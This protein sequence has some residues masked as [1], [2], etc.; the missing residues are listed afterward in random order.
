MNYWET[1]AVAASSVTLPSQR[2]AVEVLE[3]TA[4]VTG[5]GRS[6]RNRLGRGGSAF[7]TPP[8]PFKRHHHS[9]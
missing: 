8:L 9:A 2:L 7:T 4:R 6:G 5:F 3:R 1:Y